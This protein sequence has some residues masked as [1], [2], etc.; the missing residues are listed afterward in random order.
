MQKRIFNY[1]IIIQTFFLSV[2]TGTAQEIHSIDGL[3]VQYDSLFEPVTSTSIV[4]G[5]VVVFDIPGVYDFMKTNGIVFQNLVMTMDGIALPELPAYT[6]GSHSGL[7]MFEFSFPHLTASHRKQLYNLN[8]KAAKEVLIGLKVGEG[9][10]LTY[11]LQATIY[12]SSLEYWGVVGLCLIGLFIAFFIAL[13]FKYKSFVKDGVSGLNI[14]D[15]FSATYSFSKSQLAYWTFII[16]CCFIYIWA[17]TGDYATIN[18]TGLIL[19]GISAVTTT[20]GQSI[21]KNQEDVAKSSGFKSV[22]KLKEFRST[23]KNFFK[24]ILSDGDGLSIHRLQ[25]LVFNIVFGVAFV[26]TVIMEYSMP[27]FDTVQLS[28][29]GLSNGTY[30]FIKNSETKSN[31]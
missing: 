28:M 13:I 31:A 16:V 18:S 5:N 3:Y 10:S 21:N 24:D 27:E 25:A 30:A 7:V 1:L 9:V 14:T 6:I 8:G 12:F 23:D 20:V 26:R 22:N 29:L 4:S 15:Q 2:S 11:P 19:L 17:L